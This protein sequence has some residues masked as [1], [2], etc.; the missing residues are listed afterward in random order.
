MSIMEAESTGRA[1]ITSN[2]VGCRETVIDGY[3]GFMIEKKDVQSLAK[4]ILWCIEHPE[5]VEKMGKNACIFTETRFDA[6]EINRLIINFL[7]S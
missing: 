4:K 6:K 5:E 3:N 7:I 2:N 1:V